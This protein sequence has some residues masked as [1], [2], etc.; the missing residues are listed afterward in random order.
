MKLT[1][2]Q[3]LVLAASR[4][5]A[6]LSHGEIAKRTKL[7]VPIVRNAL[8]RMVDNNAIQRATLVNV[9]PLGLTE[10]D[11]YCALGVGGKTERDRF[12]AALRQS[13]IVSYLLE[14]G[15]PYQFLVTLATNSPWAVDEFFQQIGRQFGAAFV[16][17]ELMVCLRV[18]LFAPKLLAPKL[19]PQS[20]VIMTASGKPVELDAFDRGVL[21]ALARNPSDSLRSLAHK[22]KLSHSSLSYRVGQLRKKGVLLPPIWILNAQALGLQ[23]YRILVSLRGIRAEVKSVLFEF[24]ARHLNVTYLLE[25][26]GPWQFALGVLAHDAA[27]ATEIV[28]EIYD[29][30]GRAIDRVSICLIHEEKKVEFYPY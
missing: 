11:F 1:E 25:Y 8:R 12:S 10:Y 9:Y 5:D 27:T 19:R 22:M 24:C 3:A 20:P 26:L 13:P 6:D 21:S 17:A 2:Q 29:S 4:L 7:T 16:S 14:A 30:L 23:E 15:G 18:I 28:N